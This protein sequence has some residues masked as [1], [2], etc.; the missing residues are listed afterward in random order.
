MRAAFEA[1]LRA[2]GFTVVAASTGAEAL[3]LA[4]EVEPTVILLDANLPD[5]RGEDVLVELRRRNEAEQPAVLIVSGDRQLDRKVEG[6]RL[7]AD[8]YITKPVALAEL[9]AR[10]RRHAGSRHR[11]LAQLDDVLDDRRRLAQRIADLDSSAPLHLLAAELFGI[12]AE[13][14]SCDALSLTS[15][16]D[17]SVQHTVL[18]PSATR[19][20]AALERGAGAGA[21]RPM[22]DRGEQGWTCHAP[23]EITG[24]AFGVLGVAGTGDEQGTLSAV[25]DL[26]PQ[27]AG[28]VHRALTSDTAV[29]GQRRQVEAVLSDDAFWAEFQPIVDLRSGVTVGYEALTRFPDGRRPD[30][31]FRQAAGVGLGADLEIAAIERVLDTS[32]LLP[33]D[34]WL[35]I[36]VSAH[37]LIEHDLRPVLA[38]ADRRVILEITEHERVRDYRAIT[39]RM[40]HL[41]D[42][43]LGVDDAGSG[44]ASLRHIFEL[45]PELVKL[46]RT[47]IHGM[48]QDPVRTALI[49]GLL[50]FAT[51]LDASLLGE[52]IE[53][54]EDRAALERT[55]VTLGQGYLFG[56]PRPAETWSS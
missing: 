10:V 46:D 19:F 42:A 37:T 21:R 15:A 49:T 44:Y 4:T 52:G 17:G 55:G 34:T 54:A 36:N 45:Q 33:G 9:V 50:H 14:L 56:R 26:A 11:W 24:S 20:R 30:L 43:G 3:G 5:M 29:A 27:I 31:W 8:D 28:L 1:A 41:G 25:V 16:L 6:L 22:I 2:D 12:F 39:R 7:G 32:H 40:Q 47:W 51:E 18:A 53:H 38:R 13:Q 48:H 35:S 23:L